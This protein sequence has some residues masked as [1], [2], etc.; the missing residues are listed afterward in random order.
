MS[1]YLG[2]TFSSG[3]TAPEKGT[4][5][6]ANDDPNADKRTIMGRVIRLEQGDPLPPHPDTGGSADWRFVRVDETRRGEPL[7]STF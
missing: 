2:Q 1:E 3:Q 4:Y 5:Q 6:L 7:H